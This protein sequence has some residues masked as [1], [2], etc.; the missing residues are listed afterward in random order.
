M[1]VAEFIREG[2]LSKDAQEFMPLMQQIQQEYPALSRH[3]FHV[4]S[5]EG[6][7][8]PAGG[9][10]E[11]YAPWQDDNPVPGLN[12]IALFDKQVKGQ[13]LKNLL[14][15]ETFHV[16][17]GID[18]RSGKPVDPT[19]FKMKNKFMESLTPEQ[20]EVD[21]RDF[22]RLNQSGITYPSMADYY[23]LNRLDAYFRGYLSPMTDEEANDWGR[24]Y[25]PEQKTILEKAKAYLKKRD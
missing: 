5:G 20:I 12:T 2:K 25:T 8:N 14:L 19:W 16:L 17:G 4:R 1:N 7:S 15:G 21:V 3:Q 24:A 23:Q 11:V 6:L 9:H 18:P 13:A 10:S 22:S